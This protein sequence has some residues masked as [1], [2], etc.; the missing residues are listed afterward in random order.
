MRLWTQGP[1]RLRGRRLRSRRP[2][3][4][5]APGAR[6]LPSPRGGLPAPRTRGCGSSCR[7]CRIAVNA[8][9]WR[10]RRRSPPAS[11][12]A[13]VP[14]PVRPAPSSAPPPC[15]DGQPATQARRGGVFA[16][17]HRPCRRASWMS[18]TRSQRPGPPMVSKGSC[19]STQA[20][21]R[22]RANRGACQRAS[23]AAP[24]HATDCAAS[25]TAP[26]TCAS[27]HRGR[28]QPQCRGGAGAG[29][30][31]RQEAPQKAPPA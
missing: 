4:M 13:A 5:R 12:R 25:A 8:R 6:A 14:R 9:P 28:R 21:N 18:A 1:A 7:C 11:W 24:P 3:P 10:A 26:G 2:A 23:A 19:A 22:G 15:P 20:G 16:G 31:R 17:R 27:P 29:P 30:Q